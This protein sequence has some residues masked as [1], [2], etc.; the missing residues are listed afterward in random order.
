VCWIGTI[1]GKRF[2]EDVTD[3]YTDLTDANREAFGSI[4]APIVAFFQWIIVIVLVPFI[5]V[6]VF[7]KAAIEVTVE[8]FSEHRKE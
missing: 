7:L 1:M 3:T 4:G 2:L 5:L 6:G 8:M